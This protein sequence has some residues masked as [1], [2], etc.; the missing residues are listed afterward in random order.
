M[1]N[2][3]VTGASGQLALEIKQELHNSVSNHLYFQLLKTNWTSLMQ[4]LSK[5]SL[6]RMK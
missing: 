5:P 3:L 2:I 6:K 1:K 4:L